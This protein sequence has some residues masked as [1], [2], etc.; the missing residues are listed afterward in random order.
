VR[1][2]LETAARDYDQMADQLEEYSAR[3]GRM[4]IEVPCRTLPTFT[5]S[6]DCQAKS[7]TMLR[8]KPVP[9]GSLVV[10]KRLEYVLLN[11]GSHPEPVSVYRDEIA[12][13]VVVGFA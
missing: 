10:K 12:H 1:E 8:P 3:G 7:L 13:R 6:P 5:V 11:F 9:A 4:V 2:Q